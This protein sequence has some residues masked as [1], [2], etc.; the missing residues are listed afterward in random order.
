VLDDNCFDGN[1]ERVEKKRHEDKCCNLVLKHTKIM[2][3]IV[4]GI[5]LRRARVEHN[6]DIEMLAK[7]ADLDLAKIESVDD[8]IDMINYLRDKNC[9]DNPD[10]RIG[11]LISN[12]G[13]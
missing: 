13:L 2:S 10:E 5:S 11:N 12:G 8:V 4:G 6:V 9:I 1:E 3:N 7:Q